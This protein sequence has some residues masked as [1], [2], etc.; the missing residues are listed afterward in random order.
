VPRLR[1][2]GDLVRNECIVNCKAPLVGF[3]EGLTGNGHLILP[4]IDSDYN[5][6]GQ[7]INLSA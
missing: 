3:F 1:F 2:V 6:R 7:K 5:F 4:S